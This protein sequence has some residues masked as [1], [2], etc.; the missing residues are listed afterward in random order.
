M[1]QRK[2]ITL[3]ELLIIII[4]ITIVI[5]IIFNTLASSNQISKTKKYV[6][7]LE[8][9]Q[10]KVNDVRNQ[11]K[12]WNDYNP[13]EYGNFYNYLENFEFTNANSSS[14]VYKSEFDS[15]IKTL[16]TESTQYWNTN[17]DS[18]ITNYYYF[19]PKD[20]KT[21]FNLDYNYYVIV[22]FYTGNIIEKNGIY[23]VES[24]KIIH[25][26]YDSSMGNQLFVEQIYNDNTEAKIEVVEN[27]GLNQKVKIYLEAEDK[28]HLPDILDV[29]YYTSAD[30]SLKSCSYLSDYTYIESE[31]AVYFTVSTSNQYSFVVEDSNFIQYKKVD[32]EFS[33]CNPPILKD[34][35]TGIYWNDNNE[36][37]V[38]D[39]INDPKWYNYSSE[40]MR[41]ANAKTDDGNYWVWIPR[42]SYKI[43]QDDMEI[44]YVDNLS[45]LSTSKRALTGYEIHNA[46]TE[47][48]N[49][50]GFWVAK[51]QANADKSKIRITPGKTLTL[52]RMN[53]SLR[54][55]IMTN[56]QRNAILLLAESSKIEIANDLVHY[57]GGSP[58][59]KGFIE[60]IR[61]SSTNNPYGVYDLLCSE[62]ELTVESEVD[63][64]GRFRLVIK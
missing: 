11:Y 25:R 8:Q 6:S 48:G 51:F 43:N 59:E 32:Y 60:N 3:K 12:I 16:D 7:N 15:I 28:S 53:D 2:D 14:N 24:Q 64:E 34:N 27:K 35:M 54:K 30:E 52:I 4:M 61:Y 39:N 38:I 17:I 41:F 31:K 47:T 45:S 58:E 9:I 55:Q 56:E 29:F 40:Q 37:I 57:A 13:N 19:S 10:I 26:Q 36:E 33:L 21:F 23:D 62:N 5:I 22:N 50:T 63:E 1:I 46:F 49:I 20:L 44:E 42:Y 18:I